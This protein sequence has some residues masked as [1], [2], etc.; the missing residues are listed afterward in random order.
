MK[1]VFDTVKKYSKKGFIMFKDWFNKTGKPFLKT[2]WMQIVNLLV[3]FI[4]YDTVSGA[5]I[6]PWVEVITGFWIFILLVYYIFWK[7]F[8][9]EK[10]FK[11]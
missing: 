6:Y 4:V 5:E 9:A 2:N 10:M 11:K 8:G 1:N 7:L 3:L